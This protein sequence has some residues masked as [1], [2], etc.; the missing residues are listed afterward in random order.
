M[1]L[2]IVHGFAK[3]LEFGVDVPKDV[4]VKAWAYLHR[5]YIDEYVRLMQRE[6]VGWE[7]VTFLNYVLSSYPDTSWTGGVFSEAER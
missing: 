1:T 4:T 6:D 3:A 2:Y 7:F 5:H